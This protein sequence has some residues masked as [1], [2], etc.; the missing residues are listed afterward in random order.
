MRKLFS[1]P[2]DSTI[3]LLSVAP[4]NNYFQYCSRNI[5]QHSEIRLALICYSHSGYLKIQRLYRKL[6]HDFS[7]YTQLC[8]LSLHRIHMSCITKI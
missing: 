4:I 1:H 2:Q 8:Y 6:R 7:I 3:Q 5:H